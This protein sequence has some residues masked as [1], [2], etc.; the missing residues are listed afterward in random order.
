MQSNT[1]FN[2]QNPGCRRRNSPGS[3][4]TRSR[5]CAGGR[6][7][8]ETP[9]FQW[10][11]RGWRGRFPTAQ[12]EVWAQKEN[13]HRGAFPFSALPHWANYHNYSSL[14]LAAKN[15][16]QIRNMLSSGWA[17]IPLPGVA[18]PACY[19]KPSTQFL[20]RI[21][22]VALLSAPGL[23][24]IHP[25]CCRFQDKQQLPVVKSFHTARG[26]RRNMPQSSTESAINHRSHFNGS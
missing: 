3:L 18:A 8:G 11:A 24:P 1:S 14:W 26:K 2:R 22:G 7:P 25:K 20:L 4:W 13:I 12:R 6:S 23:L 9:G 15:V 17:K 10:W 21:R 16:I 19:R 5:R